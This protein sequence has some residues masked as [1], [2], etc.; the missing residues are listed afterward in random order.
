MAMSCKNCGLD[1][2]TL[3]PWCRRDP[4][5]R[6]GEHRVEITKMRNG[7]FRVECSCGEWD[8]KPTRGAAELGR[9]THKRLTQGY[10][11]RVRNAKRANTVR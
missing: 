1:G 4:A 9:A 8:D 7:K 6:T 5:I 10:V 3:C 11:R 2:Y